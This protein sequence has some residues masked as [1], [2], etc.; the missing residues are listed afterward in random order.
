MVSICSSPFQPNLFIPCIVWCLHTSLLA[1]R[2]SRVWD[3][4]NM[5]MCCTSMWK[6]HFLAKGFSLLYNNVLYKS[7]VSL[8]THSPYTCC[9]R[10]GLHSQRTLLELG[11]KKK[12]GQSL[13]EKK[14]NNLIKTTKQN[15]K[16][17]HLRKFCQTEW[18]LN[19]LIS[20]LCS[21][22]IF[23]LS[24]EAWNKSLLLLKL[25]QINLTL[26]YFDII[27]FFFNIYLFSHRSF[28][29]VSGICSSPLG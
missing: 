10:G 5:V 14:N 1:M 19:P 23:P 20:S 29:S 22:I 28:M 17:N 24:W 7:V 6:R 2:P 16:R 18:C 12:R 27:S 15:S 4:C 26:T 8:N 3:L 25:C 11:K 13:S 9:P 21:S